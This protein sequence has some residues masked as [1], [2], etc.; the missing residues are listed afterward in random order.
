L[1]PTWAANRP[2]TAG[3]FSFYPTTS[4]TGRHFPV[5][6][7]IPLTKLE[8]KQRRLYPFEVLLP[9][10]VIGNLYTSIALPHQIRTLSKK[11]LLERIGALTDL[12]TRTE[13]EERLMDHLGIAFDD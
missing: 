12:D 13:V 8:G 5:V 9:V 10:G 4:S 7:T 11:R 2:A 3:L 1:S 6:T